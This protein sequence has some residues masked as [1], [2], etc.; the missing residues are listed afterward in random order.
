MKIRSL[1]IKIIVGALGILA[2]FYVINFVLYD[3]YH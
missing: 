3:S 2:S 1:R